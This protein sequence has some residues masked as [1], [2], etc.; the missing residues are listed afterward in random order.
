MGIKKLLFALFLVLGFSANGQTVVE[1]TIEQGNTVYGLALKY[2]STVE[3]IFEANPS[4]RETSLVIGQTIIIPVTPKEV[5][6]SSKY[7]FH[8]VRS[9]ESVFSIAYKYNLKDS[10]LYWHNPV[11]DN[12]P[13][14]KKDQFLKIPK[15]PDSFR[16]GSG[17]FSSLVPP[18][19]PSYEIYVVKEGDTPELLMEEWG[20]TVLDEF[21]QFNPDA[22]K[23]WYT[24]MNL[25]KPKT[26]AIA[27]R[28]FE[29][30]DKLFD[31][32][33]GL[34]G[35][36]DTLVVACVL[37]FFT[38]HYVN[39]G[40]ARKRS[41][42]AFSYRQGIDLAVKEWRRK[43]LGEITITYFDSHNHQ[44]SVRAL[45]STLEELDADLIL[46]PM[47][48]A[49]LLQF[50]GTNMENTAVN[51][52]SKQAV[53]NSTNSWNSVVS[54]PVFWSEI[55]KSFNQ[56]Y[57]QEVYDMESET[58]TKL[59][60]VGLE[61]GLSASVSNDLIEG[62][63]KESYV[64]IKSDNSWA[65]NEE[66]AQLDSSVTYDLVI[67][68]NDPAFLLDVLRNLRAG[69]AQYRWYTHEYQA[70]DNGLVS[71]VFT[72]EQAYL[73]TSSHIDF[74]Q[75]LVNQFILNFRRE[76]QRQPDEYAI[77][78]YDNA[79]FHL[80]RLQT[81]VRK[82]RGI[83]KGFE[84]TIDQPRQNQFVEIRKFEGFRWVL[85]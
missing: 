10:T 60:V 69:H 58:K 7:T 76:Y 25:V 81:G 32:K 79:F 23:V 4:I 41:E 22:R 29:I 46:G 1:H 75:E 51:L 49:R 59:L 28:F 74:D 40:P 19:K 71:D 83:K 73:Y 30:E 55:K 31:E 24:G 18:K 80:A 38:D 82:W 2:G 21:Y 11:L 67:T 12:K 63:P 33:T 78:G 70:I 42:L 16:K 57:A 66:L 26:K 53:V 15:D 37:P 54:E 27:K 3:E 8:R 9:F 34:G 14:V 39:E 62:L 45:L 35:P 52:I 47:Y 56:R 50:S 20:F 44:D 5:I 68:E 43:S 17:E 72:K 6:D 48:S 65:Q 13:L 36:G 84:Y 61:S 77:E 64:T 85:R